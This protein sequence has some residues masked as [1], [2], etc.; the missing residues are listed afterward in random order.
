MIYVS[1]FT[2]SFSHWNASKNSRCRLINGLVKWTV[3]DEKMT[4]KC[5]H[6]QFKN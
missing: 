2:D 6:S 4:R 3:G 1:I 5:S